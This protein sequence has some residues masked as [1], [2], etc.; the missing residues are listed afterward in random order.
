MNKTSKT[1]YCPHCQA[2]R[3]TP[4]YCE[5]CRELKQTLRRARTKYERRRNPHSVHEWPPELQVTYQQQQ[6]TL[7]LLDALEPTQ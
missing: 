1:N 7:P 4:G 2:P 5:P 6:R 3:H